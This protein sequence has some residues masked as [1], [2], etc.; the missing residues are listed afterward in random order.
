[1]PVSPWRRPLLSLLVLAVG[2]V[3][4]ACSDAI[5]RQTETGAIGSSGTSQAAIAVV[6]SASFLTVENRAGLPLLDVDV[7]LKAANGLSFSKS[8]S[9]LESSEKR[10]LSL[11]ELRAND[12]TTF[13]PRFQTPKE[14]VI[15]ATDLVGKK[16]DVTV[17][18]K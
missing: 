7:I 2:S 5:S 15:T 4:M 13:N 6:T 12:G 16:Y 14:V 17:P 8:I 10:D 18:W 3:A 1:M 11:G 9:R